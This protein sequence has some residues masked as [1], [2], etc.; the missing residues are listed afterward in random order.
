ML[1]MLITGS[2]KLSSSGMLF[3]PR[4]MKSNS[5]CLPFM[6]VCMY[7][8]ICICMCL[9]I[10]LYVFIYKFWTKDRQMRTVRQQTNR[11]LSRLLA[12]TH[13]DRYNTIHDLGRLIR[14][15]HG[16]VQNACRLVLF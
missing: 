8:Y 13:S 2:W 16:N 3:T 4:F 14:N 7:M 12:T 6:Y 9:C 11:S 15:N 5:V 1:V 10:L